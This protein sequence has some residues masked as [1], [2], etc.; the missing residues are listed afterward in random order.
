M[1]TN[2]LLKQEIS[3]GLQSGTPCYPWQLCFLLIGMCL[4]SGSNSL[5]R[6]LSPECINLIAAALREDALGQG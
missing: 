2:P 3:T 5:S 6:F 4:R 1:L